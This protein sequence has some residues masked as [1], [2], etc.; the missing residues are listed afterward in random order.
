M[1][2]TTINARFGKSRRFGGSPVPNN[3]HFEGWN[4]TETSVVLQKQ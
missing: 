2:G 4:M 1:T 3:E